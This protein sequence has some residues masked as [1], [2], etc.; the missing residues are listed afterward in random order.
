MAPVGQQRR[1]EGGGRF[2]PL[3]LFRAGV[4][5][6]D[7]LVET[8]VGALGDHGKRNLRSP[9]E[10]VGLGLPVGNAR[11]LP[12]IGDLE[13]VRI[14]R[15]RPERLQGCEGRAGDR[16]VD[17][18]PRGR[19][20]VDQPA[21][22]GP[23]DAV[24]RVKDRNLV[25]RVKKRGHRRRVARD[26]RRVQGNLVPPENGIVV[27]LEPV[28]RCQGCQGKEDESERFHGDRGRAENGR[29]W[30][31]GANLGAEKAGDL[32]HGNEVGA[33][34]LKSGVNRGRWGVKP[35]P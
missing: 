3:A 33:K 34:R 2:A 13:A 1:P 16:C 28:Q 11:Q 31:G 18:R 29:C 8:A 35:P 26:P 15:R 24:Y 23:G 22:M 30:G 12:V 10:T 17:V 21:L 5:S 14:A 25:C 32:R 27:R 6:R 20:V 7:G 9:G 19:R 4:L